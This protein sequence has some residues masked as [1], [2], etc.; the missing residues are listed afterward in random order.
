MTEESYRNSVQIPFLFLYAN[1]LGSNLFF[2]LFQVRCEG[3]KRVMK[4]RLILH[5]SGMYTRLNITFLF[6]KIV[7][8]LFYVSLL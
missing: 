8:C 7:L 1:L 6:V 2:F 3:V 5:E 4:R